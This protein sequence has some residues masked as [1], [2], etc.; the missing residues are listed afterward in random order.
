MAEVVAPVE[1]VAEEKKVEKVKSVS[2]VDRVK[3]MFEKKR[4][5]NSCKQTPTS[6][7]AAFDPYHRLVATFYAVIDNL[8]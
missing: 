6:I 7:K 4:T 5:L 2:V 1:P 8:S 3:A